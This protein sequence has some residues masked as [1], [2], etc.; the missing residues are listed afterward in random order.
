[1]TNASVAAYKGG[2]QRIA[3]VF[4]L[5]LCSCV[6]AGCGGS[7]IRLT[8]FQHGGLARPPAWLTKIVARED[9]LFNDRNPGGGTSYTF[10]KLKDVV[11]MFG[12]FTGGCPANAYC[13]ASPPPHGTSLRLVISPRTHHV[14]SATLSRRIAGTQAPAIAQRSS[15]FLHI[16]PPHP[17]KVACS[18]PHGG[19]SAQPLHGRC[20]TAFVSRP[21]YRRGS[22]RIFFGERWRLGG[23]LQHAAWIVTVRLR[24]G[25]VQ[26]T[27]VTAPP[28]QLWR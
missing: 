7:H 8:A 5:L 6:A 11:V 20:M 15:R 1:V 14:L 22:I 18:I 23:R 25:R 21:P 3:G 28:P 4:A 27:Q 9:R 16:F 24:D 10:S 19:G 12:E 2:M 13:T 26:S 17:G